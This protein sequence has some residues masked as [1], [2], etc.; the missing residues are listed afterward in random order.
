MLYRN[1]GLMPDA[2]EACSTKALTTRKMSAS[3]G[4]VSRAKLQ[5]LRGVPSLAL[6][7]H[8]QKKLDRCRW[9]VLQAARMALQ[10]TQLK[11]K[12]TL[13]H[14][15]RSRDTNGTIVYPRRLPFSNLHPTSEY[16][17]R[18]PGLQIQNKKCTGT[19]NI[20]RHDRAFLHRLNVT[21]YCIYFLWQR[22]PPGTG[23]L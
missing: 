3:W 23:R 15:T 5:V 21:V 2:R 20:E 8:N 6:H 9:R 17:L 22:D 4:A 1:C 7:L 12:P 18:F 10:D 13:K 19:K 16:R 14:E 11:R